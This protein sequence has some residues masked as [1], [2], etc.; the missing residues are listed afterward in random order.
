MRLND[1]FVKEDFLWNAVKYIQ[2]ILG[3]RKNYYHYKESFIIA[4]LSFIRK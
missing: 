3:L 4:V 2:E 1:T